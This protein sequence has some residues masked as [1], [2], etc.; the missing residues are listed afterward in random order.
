VSDL[1]YLESHDL[2]DIARNEEDLSANPTAPPPP[3]KRGRPAGDTRAKIVSRSIVLFNRR[4]VANVSIG[5]IAADMKISP[6]NLTYYFKRKR[7]LIN[8][9]L[10]ILQRDL[11]IGMK[12]PAL[13]SAEEACDYVI[14]ASRAL[15]Q[16]RFFFNGLAHILGKDRKLRAI[17]YGF[18]DWTINEVTLDLERLIE[19]GYFRAPQAPNSLHILVHCLWCQWLNWLRIQQIEQPLLSEPSDAALYDCAAQI[20]CSC[21]PYLEVQFGLDLLAAFQRNLLA[22]PKLSGKA[23]APKKILRQTPQ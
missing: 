1:V 2:M 11:R 10:E 16:F 14:A 17:Y 6:G 15:W 9:C 12:R 19:L 20:W 7:D 23:S 21:Q 5:T 8:A 22:K 18:R 13:G 3:R 4:G